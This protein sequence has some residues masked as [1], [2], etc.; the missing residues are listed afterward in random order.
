M[1]F[2]YE[3][4]ITSYDVALVS[5]ESSIFSYETLSFSYGTA[6]ISHEMTRISR[7]KLFDKKIKY[8]RTALNTLRVIGRPG[9]HLCSPPYRT[10]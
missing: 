2:S 6:H 5:Y 9:N 3:A 4:S 1:V 7:S 10:S 8:K